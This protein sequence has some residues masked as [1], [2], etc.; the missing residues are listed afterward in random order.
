MARVYT[1]APT[2][3]LTSLPAGNVMI[4]S[5]RVSIDCQTSRYLG[6]ESGERP[7]KRNLS[8]LVLMT[9]RL[10]P[11]LRLQFSFSVLVFQQLQYFFIDTFNLLFIIHRLV[12]GIGD[13]E[14]IFCAFAVGGDSGI[15]YLHITLTQGCGDA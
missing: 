7:E 6:Y 13:E 10:S 9:Q 4:A 14:N 12:Q 3:G 5:L 15:L 8:V 1:V 11:T 2:P